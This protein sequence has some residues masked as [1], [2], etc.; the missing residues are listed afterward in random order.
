MGGVF[1]SKPCTL[2]PIKEK[3]EQEKKIYEGALLTF[4]GV[5][6][7]DVYNPS[8]PFQ[9]KGKNYIFGRVEKFDEW[10]QS[11]VI[12]FEETRPDEYTRVL[13]SITWN[14]EDPFVVKI[15]GEMIF[16]GTHI[17]KSAGK[18]LNYWCDFYR[19]TPENLKYFA[20]G[21]I[22]MKDVRLIEL[23]KKKVGVFSH[24]R[25]EGACL[26][27]L[28]IIDNI[29]VLSPE[30]VNSAR[31]IQHQAFGD[32]WGGPNQV[33]LLSSG[34][35]G[36]ISHHGYLQDQEEGDQLR[37]YCCTSFVLDPDTLEVHD[38]KIIATHDCFPPCIPKL[39]R[40]ADC[41]F[42]SGITMRKDGKCNLYSGIGDS[43]T[44]RVV[45]DYPFEGYGEI[46]SD[47]NF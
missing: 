11:T 27:G 38:F 28:A 5:D 34:N 16:G 25:P 17:T 4:K 6:G 23:P 43:H 10:A 14:L 21:P 46:A 45:I 41:A 37:V 40:L 29:S 8:V 2:V 39:P 42:V 36:C 31:Y 19:G 47:L 26:T 13:N 22:G 3:F 33:Y 32:A 1:L 12:L 35:L 24:F 18:I 7:F 30:V 9:Y 15:H 20:S 44:G